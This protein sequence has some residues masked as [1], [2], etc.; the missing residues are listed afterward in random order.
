V[1]ATNGRLYGVNASECAEQAED[2]ALVAR[3][4]VDPRA[5]ALLYDR[6]LDQVYRYCHRRLG[7]F[8][9]A[10]DATS[11]TFE[12]ALA[13][14]PR[15]DS[16]GGNFR[17]WLFTIAHNVV[18]N[19]VRHSSHRTNRPLDA[20]AEVKDDGLSPE[21]YAVANDEQAALHAAL[22]RLSED[23]RRII[24]LRLAGLTGHEIAAAVGMSHGAVRTAQH[25]ALLR[26]RTLLDAEASAPT[27]RANHG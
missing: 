2:A 20:A 15:F 13:A 21:A 26:L 5:F 14:L 12:K 10:Q 18:I 16:S 6:Y 4:Q 11:A 25:R 23:Q 9:A 24:E 17:G 19:T 3:A 1:K 27:E 7:S 8:A 22:A